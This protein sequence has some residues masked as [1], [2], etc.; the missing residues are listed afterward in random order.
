MRLGSPVTIGSATTA[1]TAIVAALSEISGLNA[2]ETAPDNPVAFDAF[3][4]WALTT[5]TGGRLGSLPDHE[6]DVLV[7]LP[8][9]YEPDTVLWG[10]SLLVQVASALQ[11]VGVVRTADPIQLTFST[12]TSMPALRVRVVP[13]LPIGA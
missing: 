12:G 4:R 6:Y 8:A 2:Y 5:F 7:V 10:D 11:S 1:R 13:H 3:P 9:G